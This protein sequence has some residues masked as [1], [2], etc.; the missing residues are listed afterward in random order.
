MAGSGIAMETADAPRPS[1][2]IDASIYIFQYY[3][4][5]PDNWFSDEGYPTGAVYGYSTFLLRLLEEQGCG[6]IAACFDESLGSCFRNDIYPDYKSSRAHPD[7]ALAFQL[8][9]C[10]EVTELLG[11]ACFSSQDYEADDLLGTLS[12]RLRRGNNPIAILSRDKDLGQLLHR[13]QDYLWDYSKGVRYF[14]G[15]IHKKFGVLPAQL[16][17]YLALVGDSIDDIPG[18]PGL[19]PKTAQALLSVHSTIEDIFEGIDELHLL[20]VRGARKL[21]EKL[22]CYREQI[23][24]AR[25]LATIV[26]TVPLNFRAADLEWRAARVNRDQIAEFCQRMGFQRLIARFEKVLGLRE[27]LATD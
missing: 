22:A 14:A 7:E 9:A 16:V 21:G 11:I 13:E 12:K 1:L 18:V 15:C 27:F 26:D 4:S 23:E 25:Q 20:P 19:G 17:D 10:R 24:V 3:F 2:L 6:R 5:L 8:E